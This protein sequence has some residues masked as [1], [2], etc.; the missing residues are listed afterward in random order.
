MEE[1]EKIMSGVNKEMERDPESLYKYL[2]EHGDRL[3]GET[4]E[5]LRPKKAVV[6]EEKNSPLYLTIDEL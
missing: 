1:F 3:I 2:R 6:E 5:K 4:K